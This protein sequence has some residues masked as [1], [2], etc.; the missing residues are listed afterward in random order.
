MNNT[1]IE[2]NSNLVCD[3]MSFR[4]TWKISIYQFLG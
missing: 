2:F 3:H 1:Y 4:E